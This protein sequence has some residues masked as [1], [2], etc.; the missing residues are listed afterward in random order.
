MVSL[1]SAIKEGRF[2]ILRRL[3]PEALFHN[4]NLPYVQVEY[5]LCEPEPP[6]SYSKVPKIKCSKVSKPR[7][8]L[9]APDLALTY[10]IPGRVLFRYNGVYGHIIPIEKLNVGN[11]PAIPIIPINK[12]IYVLTPCDITPQ[13]LPEEFEYLIQELQGPICYNVSKIILYKQG[14]R[15][16]DLLLFTIDKGSD[17]GIW[18]YENGSIKP[19]LKSTQTKVKQIT[20]KTIAYPRVGEEYSYQRLGKVNLWLKGIEFEHL[21]LFSLTRYVY[22]EDVTVYYRYLDLG[23]V[24]SL[25]DLFERRSR[26]TPVSFTGLLLD[27][28]TGVSSV[29]GYT[30]RDSRGLK[31]V[32]D[33][34]FDQYLRK[35]R[36]EAK[37]VVESEDRGEFIRSG[38]ALSLYKALTACHVFIRVLKHFLVNDLYVNISAKEVFNRMGKFTT[39]KSLVDVALLLTMDSLCKGFIRDDKTM[40]L[41]MIK[42]GLSKV[43]EDMVKACKRDKQGYGCKGRVAIATLLIKGKRGLKYLERA[44]YIKKE[45]IDSYL[46]KA[47]EERL[48]KFI[49]RV[50]P[51][52][53]VSLALLRFVFLH[54]YTHH[55]LK[56]LAL[57]SRLPSDYLRE[58]S[59]KDPNELLVYE[60]VSGGIGI[61]DDAL[62]SWNLHPTSHGSTRGGRV[63]RVEQE[64]VESLVLRMGEC[65]IGTS[66]DMLLFE[67]LGHPLD[68]R[69]PPIPLTPW[70]YEEYR[71]I[72]EVFRGEIERLA[73]LWNLQAN[74]LWKEVLELIK[75]ADISYMTFSSYEHVAL[76]FIR[77]PDR[78]PTI[79]QLVVKVISYIRGLDES[80]AKSVLDRLSKSS[81]VNDYIKMEELRELGDYVSVLRSIFLRLIPR[82]CNDACAMCYFN[83]RTCSYG[84]PEAQRL[85]LSRRLLKLVLLEALDSMQGTSPE[86]SI[87]WVKVGERIYGIRGSG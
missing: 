21:H 33:N 37:D 60:T 80:Q 16:E 84:N 50:V 44:R 67:S 22:A 57:A 85:L 15:P 30:I 18:S 46:T 66:E 75:E 74:T 24:Q 26:I 68:P 49:D 43:L 86:D 47:I 23:K 9:E 55:V 32:L 2:E 6:P 7:I 42:D 17:Y 62:R 63:S 4:T 59:F 40:A 5:K 1:R 51:E 3:I 48:G 13:K 35:L 78:Y 12:N 64:G 53:D 41:N 76:H 29:I 39:L 61:I 56:H 8:E 36:D 25:N 79:K 34:E 69:N 11:L 72:R 14:E 77:N 27:A 83:Q 45:E 54:T 73:K 81:Q 31:I 10:L 87:A 82:T 19:L 71:K 20:A 70:E 58:E 65:I 28:S 52:G 38:D